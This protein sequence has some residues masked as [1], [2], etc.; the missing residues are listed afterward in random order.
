MNWLAMAFHI[1][2]GTTALVTGT[3]ALIYRKGRTDHSR[4]GT[5]FF[6]SML[7]MAG[8][9][10]AIAASKPD[11][12]T[13]LAGIITAYLVVTSWLAIR[14]RD[15]VTGRVELGS[16][17]FALG[18][19]MAGIGFGQIAK[20]SVSGAIDG[21]PP[22]LC[23]TFA[24]LAGLCAALDLNALVRRKLAPRQRI[25]RHLW[26]MSVAFF[27]AAA[28]LFLGQ[29]DDVFWF[30]QGSILLYIPPFATLAV[31]VYWAFRMRWGRGLAP[32]T[33]GQQDAG[34]SIPG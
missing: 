18:C 24:A 23:Y 4:W 25:A 13:A 26:R 7:V 6:G 12:P 27:L 9:G 34:L 32:R 16:F 19:C 2:A 20:A 1:G 3:G 22:A 11:R 30:M 28:S 29:Q 33:T 10:A 21:Y 15:G 5:W 31:M 14:R 8:L 17:I